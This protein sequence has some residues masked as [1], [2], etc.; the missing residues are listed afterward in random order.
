MPIGSGIG[1]GLEGVGV[2]AGLEAWSGFRLQTFSS[3][4]KK[5]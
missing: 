3:E 5:I 1:V 4:D 2:V